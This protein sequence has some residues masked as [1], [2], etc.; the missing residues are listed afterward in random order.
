MPAPLPTIDLSQLDAVTGGA[1][2]DDRILDKITSITS[3]VADVAARQQQNQK[4][5]PAASIMPIVAMKMMRRQ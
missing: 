4:P 3:A 2:K 1:T 5:D